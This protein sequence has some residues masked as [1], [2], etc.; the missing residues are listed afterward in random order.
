M[1]S[2][3]KRPGTIGPAANTSIEG[4]LQMKQ[5]S[6]K[7][8]RF[9]IEYYKDAEVRA[10]FWLLLF[11][12]GLGAVTWPFA[13]PMD[14]GSEFW[15]DIWVTLV[16]LNFDVFFILLVFAAFLLYR[17]DE[18]EKQ[19]LRETIDDF[20]TWG[21]EEEGRL[22]L[23][24]AIRRLNAKREYAIN[25][26]GLRLQKFNFIKSN[27]SNIE[28]STFF[29]GTVSGFKDGEK[30]ETVMG[31]K[32][33][34]L[35]KIRLASDGPVQGMDTSVM[36]KGV[37]FDYVNCTNVIFSPYEPRILEMPLIL[38]MVNPDGTPMDKNIIKDKYHNRFA[39]FID[40]SFRKAILEGATFSGASLRWTKKPDL[41]RLESGHAEIEYPV[42]MNGPPPPFQG[43][44]L[45][46]VNFS[47][48]VFENA[49]FRDTINLDRAI[50]SKAKGLE[51]AVFH[52]DKKENKRIKEFILEQSTAPVSH[53]RKLI[54]PLI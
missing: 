42:T 45:K 15:I 39:K 37:S 26:A 10:A 54:P 7:F 46:G 36:L 20:K 5:R 9:I 1:R 50:F 48:C 21:E 19:S 17:R 49:D 53:E 12:I 44:S 29:D 34:E 35:E 11:C 43:T 6:S 3:H 25:F 23:A 30:K 16:G 4:T 41:E 8:G 27:I 38:G 2:L 22:L 14:K 33:I 28:G 24:G 47:E 51:D 40:C 32:H 52:D 13:R 31:E 18:R